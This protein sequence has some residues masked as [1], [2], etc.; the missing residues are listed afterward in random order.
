M[1][2]KLCY[3]YFM[4]KKLFYVQKTSLVMMGIADKM[5]Y[6]R[7]LWVTA[8]KHCSYS[9]LDCPSFVCTIFLFI[10]HFAYD[11]I[12]KTGSRVRDIKYCANNVSRYSH[13]TSFLLQNPSC[14]QL[15]YLV[16]K[17]CKVVFSGILG[18]CDAVYQPG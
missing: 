15:V 1:Y 10:H 9:T 2:Q 4:Y 6:N 7:C 16:F 12:S 5:K 14:I 3:N 17:V 8:P 18:G 13:K 11:V